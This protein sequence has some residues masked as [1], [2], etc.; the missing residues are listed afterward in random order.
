MDYD[1]QDGIKHKKRR[2]AEKEATKRQCPKCGRV[3]NLL[4]ETDA[5]DWA[6][7]HD[8]VT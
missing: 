8:C 4:D 6:Y 2:D 3:F 7:I 5:T 1:I